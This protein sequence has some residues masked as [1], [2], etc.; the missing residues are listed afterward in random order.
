V[1][2]RED[3]YKIQCGGENRIEEISWKK[4]LSQ[5]DEVSENTYFDFTNQRVA[6]A[7]IQFLHQ[8]QLAQLLKMMLRHAWAT[9]P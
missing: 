6:P 9:E 2:Q 3:V 8:T 1:H 7:Y 5:F 4:N